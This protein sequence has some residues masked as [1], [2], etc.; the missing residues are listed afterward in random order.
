MQPAQA[1]KKIKQHN[2][3]MCNHTPGE[4]VHMVYPRTCETVTVFPCRFSILCRLHYQT[5]LISKTSFVGSA[6]S[7]S[8][9]NPQHSSV[10]RTRHLQ[11]K[12][13]RSCLSPK[14]WDC[15]SLR[16]PDWSLPSTC[17]PK[18]AI[19]GFHLTPSQCSSGTTSQPFCSEFQAC[20]ARPWAMMKLVEMGDR[21]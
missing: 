9:Q 15:P 14:H 3:T 16:H 19:P 10:Q 6:S 21:K 8:T 4:R 18:R 12:L 17:W 1:N 5:P 2:V 7:N 20:P 13:T 11:P